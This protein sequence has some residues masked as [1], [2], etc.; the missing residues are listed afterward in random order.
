MTGRE[1]STGARRAVVVASR[2]SAGLGTAQ[3]SSSAPMDCRCVT[4]PYEAAAE[5]LRDPPDLVAVEMELISQN[6]LP[7]LELARSKKA[8]IVGFGRLPAGLSSDELRG[9]R[10]IAFEELSGELARQAP[11]PTD[12][13]D[14]TAGDDD[15]ADTA[16]A[17]AE[18]DVA[19]PPAAELTQ[20]TPPQPERP[21]EDRPGG[22]YEPIPVDED[23][24]TRPSD[25][26]AGADPANAGP[27][28][29]AADEEPDRP[30]AGQYRPS[31]PGTIPSP[32]DPTSLLTPE[33]LA[34]LLED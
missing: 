18:P 33:E 8:E 24:T 1:E 5:I 15:S 16:P 27:H 25:S 32:G 12:T 21:V 30:P 4:S 29:P 34:A 23:Y 6:H 2:Q 20:P 28:E 26:A 10:L 9:L 11:S 14:A 17:P 22:E 7:L 19:P 13:T 31:P 3:R